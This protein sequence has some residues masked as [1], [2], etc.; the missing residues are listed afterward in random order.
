[1]STPCRCDS[2]TKKCCHSQSLSGSKNGCSGLADS[3]PFRRYRLMVR[4]EEADQHSS[5]ELLVIRR[6]SL[7]RKR[8]EAGLDGSLGSFC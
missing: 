7:G 1:M 2:D 6:T 4:A 8:Y 3:L 5:S